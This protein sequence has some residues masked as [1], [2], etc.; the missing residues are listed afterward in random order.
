VLT[1]EEIIVH[2]GAWWKKKNI[3]P[4]NRVTNI[5]IIQG[6]VARHFGL[7]KISIQTAG[8]S[9]GAG[10]SHIGPA[11]AVI[12]GMKNF[13]EIKDKIMHHVRRRKPVAT[14]AAAEVVVSENVGQQI[15]DELKSIRKAL[16]K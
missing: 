7:G 8:F 12:L 5:Q 1:E 6:P 16:E 15:L 4:Y 13:E 2:K 9:G 10:S 11:E 14:E 3:V